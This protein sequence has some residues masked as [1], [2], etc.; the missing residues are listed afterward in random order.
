MDQVEENNFQFNV[1]Q[2]LAE[3]S[4]GWTTGLGFYEEKLT[5]TD[6]KLARYR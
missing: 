5:T 2:C 1:G 3:S 4:S 6:D